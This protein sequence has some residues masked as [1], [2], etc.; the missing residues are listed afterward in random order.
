M[1]AAVLR[2]GCMPLLARP[3]KESDNLGDPSADV[4]P[5]PPPGFFAVFVRVPSAAQIAHPGTLTHRPRIGH[6]NC[7][8]HTSYPDLREGHV[9]EITFAVCL[10]LDS[11]LTHQP[12]SYTLQALYP[13]GFYVLGRKNYTVG[14]LLLHQ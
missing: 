12:D 7:D 14:T 9:Q 6:C 1:T 10:L 8:T 4:F 13:L 11:A 2:V 5:D 3:R